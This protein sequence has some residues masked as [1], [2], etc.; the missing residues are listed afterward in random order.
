MVQSTIFTSPKTRVYE[1]SVLSAG[2]PTG[3]CKLLGT[4]DFFG[5]FIFFDGWFKSFKFLCY[6]AM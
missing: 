4:V 2:P 6:Y 1:F 5:I 3:V